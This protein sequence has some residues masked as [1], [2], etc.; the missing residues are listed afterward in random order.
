MRKIVAF[1]A[2]FDPLMPFKLLIFSLDLVNLVW[3][4]SKKEFKKSN[5]WVFKM[6]FWL[7][8]EIVRKLKEK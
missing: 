5:E 7:V 1:Q 2:H 8:K 6:I 3:G 4:K